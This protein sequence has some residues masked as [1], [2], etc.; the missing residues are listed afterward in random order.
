ELAEEA[1]LVADTWQHLITFCTTPGGSTE[2]I[3][4]YLARGLRPVPEDERYERTEEEADL[5]PAWIPLHDGVTA[6]LGGRLHSP[7]TGGGVLTAAAGGAARGS[8]PPTGRRRGVAR[9]SARRSGR[10]SGCRPA[11][12]CGPD[13]G[14]DAHLPRAEQRA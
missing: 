13:A 3:A 11:G 14:V 4:I 12:R 9:S 10:R 1:D 8:C 2:T 7:T 6:A 5:E